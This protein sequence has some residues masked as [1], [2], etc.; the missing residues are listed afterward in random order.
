MKSGYDVDGYFHILPAEEKTQGS[1]LNFDKHRGGQNLRQSLGFTG[2]TEKHPCSD[3]FSIPRLADPYLD[4]LRSACGCPTSCLSTR[5]DLRYRPF[6]RSRRDEQLSLLAPLTAHSCSVSDRRN[7]YPTRQKRHI[8]Y[9]IYSI[10]LLKMNTI[11]VFVFSGS[12]QRV[13]RV[14]HAFFSPAVT[15]ATASV[16]VETQRRREWKKRGLRPEKTWTEPLTKHLM[17][18]HF[19]NFRCFFF[20]LV[21]FS[22]MDPENNWFEENRGTSRVLFDPGPIRPGSSFRECECGDLKRDRRRRGP[23]IFPFGSLLYGK[24]SPK[25]EV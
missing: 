23:S 3:P 9:C 5:T 24:Q 6:A 18:V 21:F 7:M 10:D 1:D 15:W 8:Y 20:F 16:G 12:P 19:H 22:T 4:P 17:M 25:L 13:E 11:D 2:I 14:R